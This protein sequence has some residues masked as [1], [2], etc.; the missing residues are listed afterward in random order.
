MFGTSVGEGQRLS[1]QVPDCRQVELVVD[2]HE[3][4]QLLRF[5]HARGQTLVLLE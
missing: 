1:H 5:T 2:G 4:D 3:R